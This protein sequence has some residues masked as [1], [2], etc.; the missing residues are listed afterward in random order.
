[1]LVLA[2][3]VGGVHIKSGLVEVAGESAPIVARTI[4]EDR[5]SVV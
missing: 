3:D 1:M 2:F 5:K 4:I